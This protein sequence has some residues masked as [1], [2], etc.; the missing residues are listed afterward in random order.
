MSRAR[1]FNDATARLP[2]AVRR[3]PFRVYR[4]FSPFSVGQR[5][6]TGSERE[7]GNGGRQSA[8]A[9]FRSLVCVADYILSATCFSPSSPLSNSRQPSRTFITA[10]KVNFASLPP[11]RS[12]RLHRR[13]P[14][15]TR[16]ATSRAPDRLLALSA[17]R[18]PPRS[19][20]DRR[21]RVVLRDRDAFRHS[22]V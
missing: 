20:L 1:V 8:N 18:R 14:R 16:L 7:T 13:P 19:R 3:F 17:R 5:K 2:T 22:R 6:A 21:S 15:R 12:H 10:A 9:L 11:P 4:P